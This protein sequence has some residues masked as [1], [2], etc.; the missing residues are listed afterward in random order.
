MLGPGGAFNRDPQGNPI[1]EPMRALVAAQQA[2]IEV[3]PCSG[4]AV[5][6]LT[7]DG[8]I[9]GME[10]VIAEMG[11][12]ISYGS[13]R[14][15]VPNLGA[16]PG[17][18]ELPTHLMQDS[19]AVKLLTERFRVELHTPWAK[20]REYTQLFRGLVD[21]QE[22]NAA[23]AD[24]G[25]GWLEL[26]DNGG[27]HA[28]YLDLDPGMAHAYHL[29]PRGVSKGSA[30]AIDQT[31]RSLAPTDCIAIGD[32][33]ADCEI[34]PHVSALV[35]VRD[36]VERDPSLAERAREIDNVIVT[37]RPGIL[38]WTDTMESLR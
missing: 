27:L 10:T 7:G 20:Y 22:A 37:D 33:V 2:G 28:A 18:D 15:I 9:L 5:R 25:L 31:R 24:A 8:R 19:G 34:A 6:G 1:A 30:I 36:A 11:A 14:E 38:G 3:V 16:F 21:T 26:V 17:G 13:G 29:L 4:R 12:V 32:A 23:L 35:L